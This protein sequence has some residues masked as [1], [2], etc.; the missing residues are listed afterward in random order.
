MTINSVKLLALGAAKRV[1]LFEQMKKLFSE[2]GILLEVTS[3]ELNDSFYPISSVGD[4][5]AGPK[6]TDDT[7]LS[8]LGSELRNRGANS[9]AFMD[10][11]IPSLSTFSGQDFGSGRVIS[12][13]VDGANIALSKQITADFC[14]A[15]EIRHPQIFDIENQPAREIPLIAK[16]IE[17][18]GSKGISYFS[19]NDF[20]EHAVK[21]EGTHIIQEF[22]KGPETTH[23]L[24]IDRDLNVISSSRDRLSVTGGEV[25]HCLV[26]ASTE[27]EKL[28]FNKLARTG[29]FRGPITVQTIM[30]ADECFMIEV[31]ARLGGGVTGSVQ[32][33]FPVIQKWAEESIGVELPEKE[34]T[35]IEMK[36]CYRDF[37]RVV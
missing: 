35:P 2:A 9:L 21:C 3:V 15:N 29:L 23:D 27:R 24:Y 19:S 7:F 31:N 4:V 18:F 30:R 32:A 11:A 12:S 16:P 37:Y 14:F 6:F 26:R 17:G 34:F 33:G 5:I 20:D 10:A 28:I 8:F 25:D 13:S 1:T 36:R 22:I